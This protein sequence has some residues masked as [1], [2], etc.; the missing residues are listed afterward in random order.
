MVQ[1]AIGKRATILDFPG[2]CLVIRYKGD[3][4]PYRTF[5]KIRQVK[6]MAIVENERR[7]LPFCEL[8]SNSPHPVTGCII[9]K[10]QLRID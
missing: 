7:L 3:D 9:G 1:L 2:G 5:D 10:F 8:R 6:Q 4:Q